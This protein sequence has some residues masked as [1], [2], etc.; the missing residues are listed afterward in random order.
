MLPS[1]CVA[2]QPLHHLH[3]QNLHVGYEGWSLCQGWSHAWPSGLHLLCGGDGAGKS[4][5]LRV[6]AGAQ[7][8]QAGQIGLPAGNAGGIFWVDPRQ[9]EAAL[10]GA[11]T[12]RHWLPRLQ[13]R[14]VHWDAKQWQTHV[15]HWQLE[16][17]QDKPWH[18]L[19]TG[20][21][22]K[23]WMAAALAS[24]AD[25]VLIDEPI[26][27]LDRPSV[28]YLRQVLADRSG[29]AQ[30]CLLVA[31][32]DDLQGLPWDSVVELEQLPR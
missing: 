22:R 7:K 20:T 21:A 16:E 32:Y 29:Q 26:A 31:H 4:T 13:A 28:A 24:G 19:S 3:L 1:D 15:V 17:A 23:L 8:P 12:A 11:Q 5:L 6:L 10:E 2:V 25:L 27:G 30:Q 14:Y 18:A 9:P